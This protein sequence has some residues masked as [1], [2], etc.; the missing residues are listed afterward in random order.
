MLNLVP[1]L[2]AGRPL[3]I[4]CIGAHSDDL[5]IGCGATI[6][7]LLAGARPVEVTWVVLCAGGARAHEARR[8]ARALLARAATHSIRL[9]Q[10]PDTRLGAEYA[11]LKDT[12]DELGR[13]TDPHVVL[14]HRLEDRHQDHRLVAELTWNTFRDHVILEY[15]IPKYEGDLGNPNLYVP[16]PVAL[17]RRKV[18]HIEKVFASQRGKHWF[19]PETFLGLMRIRGVE[20]RSR[21]GL[22]EAFHARK[23]RLG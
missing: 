16:V 20:C 6:L 2:P 4:L 23:L 3:R 11:G 8:S 7:S 9:A 17:A 21:T 19:T 18:R 10:Y 5:E 13:T 12:F 22:A 14:S 1:D 15:E